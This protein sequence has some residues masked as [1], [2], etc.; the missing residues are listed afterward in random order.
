MER[1]G[2]GC[3][4]DSSGVFPGE[5]TYLININQILGKRVASGRVRFRTRFDVGVF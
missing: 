2:F 4:P 1:K 5:V 3:I